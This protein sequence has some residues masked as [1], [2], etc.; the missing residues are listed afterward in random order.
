MKYKT[1]T[2][3]ALAGALS[4]TGCNFMM[5]TGEGFCRLGE[6]MYTGI[7]E[8]INSMGANYKKQPYAIKLS[9]NQEEQNTAQQVKENKE[10]EEDLEGKLINQ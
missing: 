7:K 9:E 3:V 1:L 8:D 5:R 2:H 4:M 10:N 6:R